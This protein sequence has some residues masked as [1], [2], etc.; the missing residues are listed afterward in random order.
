MYKSVVLLNLVNK[1]NN[2]LKPV[3]NA[4]H[5]FK[6]GTSRYSPSRYYQN[7]YIMVYSKKRRAEPSQLDNT[8]PKKWFDEHYQTLENSSQFLYKKV[9]YLPSHLS[10]NQTR[11]GHVFGSDMTRRIEGF[12][13]KGIHLAAS[14]LFT[15]AYSLKDDSDLGW[16]CALHRWHL[17]QMQVASASEQQ[18]STEEAM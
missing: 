10:I 7:P 13:L 3:L 8:E 16:P 1:W 12:N 9:Y 18:Q 2:Q 4:H 15:V 17:W 14:L 11:I 6:I 5:R